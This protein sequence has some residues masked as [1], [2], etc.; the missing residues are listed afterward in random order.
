MTKK[1]K[2]RIVIILIVIL[3]IAV[4]V[5]MTNTPLI[6]D[7]VL[8][9]KEIGKEAEAL[10]LL[11]QIDG[12][13]ELHEYYLELEAMKP[14]KE[15][16]DTYFAAAKAEIDADFAIL[17]EQ[18]PLKREYQEGVVEA[19]WE[20]TP[21]NIIQSDGSVLWDKLAP[22]GV[23]ITASVTLTC[24]K[25]ET[26]YQF[27]FELLP[28]ELSKEEQLFTAL[29]I[30]MEEQLQKEGE[31]QLVLPK[32]IEGVP[33]Q[34]TIEEENLTLKILFLEMAAILL[35][36]YFQKKNQRQEKLFLQREM[37][38]F[39]P[40][41]V[42]QMSLLLGAGMT[43][44]QA[45]SSIAERYLEK[46][47][48]QQ[49]KEQFIYELIVRMNRRMA[50]GEKERI[51]YQR[52]AEEARLICYKRLIRLLLGNLEKGA[53]GICEVLEQESQRAYEERIKQAKKLAEEAST[54][55]LLPLMLMM[56]VV[57]AIAI[58]PAMFSF[59]I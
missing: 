42:G 19:V 48:K 10:C 3:L 32:E 49:M 30:W 23:I 27:S 2:K 53:A 21:W 43:M 9:R 7:G 57:M 44:R 56:L 20:F 50:E 39:Y 34:W 46:R 15:E 22:E 6:E 37:E 8:M 31:Q 36:W 1:D 58:I 55:L 38:L 25:Y 40:E 59:S 47:N 45:W 18:V 29:D 17:T 24:G 33:L 41:L 16:A 54:R 28:Q 51:A 52:F 12:S 13:K 26:I 35:L 11:L 4:G 5:D 14:T